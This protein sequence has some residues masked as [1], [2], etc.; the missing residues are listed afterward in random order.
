MLE[1]W[2]SVVHESWGPFIDSQKIELQEIY[3]RVAESSEGGS[4]LPK[5]T[6]VLRCLSMPIEDIKVVIIGQD[7]YPNSDDAC[8]L[9]FASKNLRVPKSLRNIRTEL[10]DDLGCK[11]TD[12]LDLS[13]WHLQG[14]LLLNRV[15]TIKEGET[16]SHINLGWEDF[17]LALLRHLDKTQNFVAILWGNSAISIEKHL[18]NT[19]IVKSPH[20][21]PLS[22]HR[23]FFGSKPFSKTNQAL[24]QLGKSPIDWCSAFTNA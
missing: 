23:G 24:L 13:A 5:P 6:Q 14:V 12:F 10:Q 21:S 19:K 15:L 2:L 11:K 9:A 8:G 17:T 16:N 22:A 3:R 1:D 4:V 18:Q 20:P 7:P